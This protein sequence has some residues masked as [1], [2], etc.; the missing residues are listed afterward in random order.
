MSKPD[1][2]AAYAESVPERRNRRLESIAQSY[3]PNPD[4]EQLIALRTA[5]PETYKQLM[6]PARR[7]RRLELA[8]YEAIKAAHMQWQKETNE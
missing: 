6:T 5:D 1:L 2:S 4:L 3:K 8:Q 7:S